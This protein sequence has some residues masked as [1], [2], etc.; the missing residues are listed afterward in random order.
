MDCCVARKIRPDRDL[1]FD[2]SVSLSWQCGK[3]NAPGSTLCADCGANKIKFETTKQCH[4]TWNGIMTAA[5]PKHTEVFYKGVYRF[6]HPKKVTPVFK[7]AAR[8]IVKRTALTEE[9]KAARLAAKDGP[10]KI[11]AKAL[12]AALG[13]ML[14]EEYRNKIALNIGKPIGE[15]HAKDLARKT[16]KATKE[17]DEKEAARIAKKATSEGGSVASEEKE[18]DEE[19]EE[20]KEEKDED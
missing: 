11:T 6:E 14:L 12:D 5:P 2:K 3:K 7:H 15:A 4:P 10:K 17:W 18:E 20:E 13:A 19:E 9:E 1:R 8:V 16:E